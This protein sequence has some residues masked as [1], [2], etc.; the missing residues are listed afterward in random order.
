M[1]HKKL[2]LIYGGA[3]VEHDISCLS[4]QWV[5]NNVPS[6]YQCEPILVDRQS[7]WWH[8]PHVLSSDTE[9]KNG[10]PF[11]N[12]L[13]C[14][15]TFGT[16]E[17][18]VYFIAIHGTGGEDGNLQGAL[19]FANA[20]F[21]GCNTVT[22]SL[23]MDKDFAK[24]IVKNAGILV[25]DGICVHK[26]L[27]SLPK[28]MTYPVFVKPANLGSSVGV[29]R[30]NSEQELTHAVSHALTFDSKVLIEAEIVGREVE[31]AIL[32]DQALVV[33]IPG[34][35]ITEHSFY[36][37]E[38]K[39]LDKKATRVQV[40]AD[41]PQDTLNHLQEQGLKAA[42]A[43]GVEGFARIDFF[44]TEND[45]SVVFN[46]INTIPGLTE[47]SLFPRLWQYEGKS[48]STVLDIIFTAA[49]KRWKKNQILQ[50][51]LHKG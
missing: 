22:S 29:S 35:V 26:T 16:N 19:T 21:T 15:E 40:P 10:K 38:A 45:S 18:T 14:L 30:V 1:S 27:N 7:Q 44:V 48:G 12:F 41:L 46:E 5:Y 3:S 49:I 51:S 2:I 8:T 42:K 32:E 34:E 11:H 36:S 50:R 47:Y 4:A 24:T 17:D 31:C 9:L 25:A 39:Y 37:Y 23:S 33:S 28:H 13:D 43:L 6:G 20:I